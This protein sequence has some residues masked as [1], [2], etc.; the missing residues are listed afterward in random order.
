M[1]TG[2][3]PKLKGIYLNIGA[4]YAIIGQI[5]VFTPNRIQK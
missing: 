1:I 2:Y 4:F 3:F 5:T